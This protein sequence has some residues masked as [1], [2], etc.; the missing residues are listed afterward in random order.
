MNVHGLADS[1][2]LSHPVEAFTGRLVTLRP[3]GRSDYECFYRWRSD[4]SNVHFWTTLRRVPTVEEFV[5][6]MDQALRPSI[7]FLIVS[8]EV[9][10]P[11]GFTQAYSL[12]LSDAWCFFLTYLAPDSRWKRH[13]AEASIALLDYLFRNFNFRKIYTDVH[14]FNSGFVDA[15][16]QA[17]FVEEGRLR[18]HTWYHDRYWDQIRLALYREA[19]PD[20]RDL[21]LLVLHAGQDVD[22]QTASA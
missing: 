4:I 9:G 3:V 16:L 12:N 1:G 19:W 2:R 6:E 5:A 20:L 7:T 22:E 15:A 10:D 14:E 8:T 18:A 17:G 21:A 11:I 13:G